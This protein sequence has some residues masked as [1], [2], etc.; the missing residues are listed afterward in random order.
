MRFEREKL[1]LTCNQRRRTLPV[2]ITWKGDWTS[3]QTDR[4]S[5]GVSLRCESASRGQKFSKSK[6]FST[7]FSKHVCSTFQ[8]SWIILSGKKI[9]RISDRIS[10]QSGIVMRF[11]RQKLPLTCN[12]RKQTLPVRITWKG[13]WTSDRDF[14]SQTILLSFGSAGFPVGS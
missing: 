1:P 12:Q 6:T 2:R 4:L 7:F 14:L 8:E 13:D 5:S 3:G 11:E 10:D 9:F